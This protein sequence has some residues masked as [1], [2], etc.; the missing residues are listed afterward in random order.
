MYQDPSR[1]ALMRAGELQPDGSEC[2]HGDDRL[3]P[4]E[5]KDP[6]GLR[7]SAGIGAC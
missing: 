2:L 7:E 5:Q 3:V 4:A 1:A 6:P